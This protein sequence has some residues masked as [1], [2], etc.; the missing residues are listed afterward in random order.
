MGGKLSGNGKSPTVHP[1]AGNGDNSF[2]NQGWTSPGSKTH[3]SK[4]KRLKLKFRRLV[5]LIA[6]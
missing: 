5:F 6:F 4:V 2:S 1:E 3:R